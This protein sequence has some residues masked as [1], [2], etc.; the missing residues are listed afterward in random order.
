MRAPDAARLALGTVVLVRPDLPG[1]IVGARSASH[2]ADDRTLRVV[3]ILGARYVAQALAGTMVRRPWVP[4]V[5]ASV[6]LVHAASMVALTRLLPAHRR[7][8]AG[9]AVAAVLFAAAD[10]RSSL[11]VRA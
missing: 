8:A 6:D 7:L 4:A 9:S 3:R 2:A 10:L 5:D 1:R 11:A